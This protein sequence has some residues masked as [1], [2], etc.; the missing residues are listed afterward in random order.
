MCTH[1]NRIISHR[2]YSWRGD[3]TQQWSQ[4]SIYHASVEIQRNIINFFFFFSFFNE[5]IA[6][7][8]V[9][10]YII[11][12]LQFIL[13]SNNKKLT[14]TINCLKNSDKE[15]REIVA[16]SLSRYFK[17]YFYS[18]FLIFFIYYSADIIYRVLGVIKFVRLC[19]LSFYKQLYR[20]YLNITDYNEV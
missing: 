5:Y 17:L 3:F 9:I 7:K 15:N 16:S 18:N 10:A 1:V 8:C 11:F 13:K 19:W 4:V 20:I 2:V 12:T 14:E 6:N